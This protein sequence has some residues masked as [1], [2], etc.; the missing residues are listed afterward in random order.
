MKRCQTCREVKALCEY[1]KKT[2]SPDGHQ[3]ECRAC[4]NEYNRNTNPHRMYVAGKYIPKSHPNWKSGRYAS[5]AEALG[6]SS[7]A[8]PKAP[9]GYVYIVY[10]LTL[11]NWY[12]VGQSDNAEKRLSQYQ[13]GSP[14]RDYE[15][16]FSEY[17]EDCRAAEKQVHDILRKHTALVECKNEW[18][19]MEPS[20]I[21][22]VIL[23]VKQKEIDSGYRD[24]LG[25]QYNL[26]LCHG[27]SSDGRDSGSYDSRDFTASVA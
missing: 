26:G 8:L 15:L 25:T 17:F 18:F 22:K 4:I 21:R 14:H 2:A 6:Q 10:N 16:M 3:S 12:K 13:T 9:D 24:E 19:N 20:I 27:G 23:D 11:G 5:W 7:K 1:N